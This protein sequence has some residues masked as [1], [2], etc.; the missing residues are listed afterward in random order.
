MNLGPRGGS[1]SST[2]NHP[3]RQ[4][5]PQIKPQDLYDKIEQRWGKKMHQFL[6]VS[7]AGHHCLKVYVHLEKRTAQLKSSFRETEPRKL[8]LSPFRV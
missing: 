2:V 8:P 5:G 1:P 3:V 6:C 7:T 4:E